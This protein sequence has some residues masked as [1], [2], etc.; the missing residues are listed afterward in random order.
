M[1]AGMPSAGQRD[2]IIQ[3]LRQASRPLDDD[4]LAKRATIS[5][6][7][8]V[9]RICRALEK[10]NVLRRY[11]GPDG[12]I[13]NELAT[14]A[15][16]GHVDGT[17]SGPAARLAI[18]APAGTIIAPAGDH[19]IPPGSSHEQRDTERTM[20]DILGQRLGLGLEPATISTPSGARIEV[21]GADSGRTVLV[22]CWAHQGPPKSAQRHK[23]L[24]DAFKLT[25]ISRTMSPRPRL[26]LCLADT[27]A[28]APF[29]PGGRSWAA[30]AFQDLSI[31]IELVDLPHDVRHALLKAQQRQY[32]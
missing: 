16:S 20:L 15:D 24:A 19:A 29:T 5:P 2:R 13:V 10:A 23:V 3:V 17:G 8:T 32:R 18:A 12:K 14:A 11:P 28:A 22:E 6:R 7:Q 26:V 21:D 25:W 31:T 30:Q 1:L 4:D 9:N 27:L